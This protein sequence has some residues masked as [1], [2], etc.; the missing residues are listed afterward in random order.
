MLGADLLSKSK[1]TPIKQPKMIDECLR[2]NRTSVLC[3][4]KCLSFNKFY[5]DHVT[6]FFSTFWD[7][8]LWYI[9]L[10]ALWTLPKLKQQEVWSWKYPVCLHIFIILGRS[11]GLLYKHRN[12]SVI[13]FLTKTVLPCQAQTV[14]YKAFSHQI[15]YVTQPLNIRNLNFCY[16]IICFK[17]W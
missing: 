3:S 7:L 9:L 12:N 16:H 1:C 11:Q 8:G 15:C 10:K 14:R 2:T 5:W 4:F 17:S 13:V 6:D